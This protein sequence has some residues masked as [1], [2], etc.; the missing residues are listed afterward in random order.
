MS[1]GAL[2]RKAVAN[3]KPLQ[4]V[5]AVNAYSAILA[6]KSG[7]QAIYLSGGACAAASYG[8]PDLGITTINDVVEDIRRITRVTKV[9]L[10]VDADTGFGSSFNIARTIEEFERAGAAGCHIEDQVGAK[11]CGHRPGKKIVSTDEMVDRIKSAVAARK[12]PN[13]VIMARTDALANEGIE[14]AIERSKAYIAAG[15]DMLFPE[16]LTELEQYK[17]FRA[18]LPNVP[19]L[20]NITE[21]GK[22]PYFTTEELSNAGASMVLYPLSAFRAQAAA[23]LQVYDAIKK[24]GTQQNVVKLMQTRE[25]LYKYLDYHKFENQLDVLFGEGK[26]Q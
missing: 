9:P 16:A 19:I 12:D 8:L 13:F 21:F 7:Y 25:D 17:Q 1:A 6:D 15:A 10:L 18:A 2:F 3:A 23:T 14:K 26:E 24:D 20:A 5:G 4:I 11:R 22:T